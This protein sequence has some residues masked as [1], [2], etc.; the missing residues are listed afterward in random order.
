MS[1]TKK[2]Q[3]IHNVGWIFPE[4]ESNK[5]YSELTRCIE[6]SKIPFIMTDS[7]PELPC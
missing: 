2:S 1:E 3:L 6:H 4:N 7:C 5:F